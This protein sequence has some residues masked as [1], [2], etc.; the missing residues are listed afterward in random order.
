MKILKELKI[1]YQNLLK[2]YLIKEIR[3]PVQKI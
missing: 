1:S 3:A 2:N